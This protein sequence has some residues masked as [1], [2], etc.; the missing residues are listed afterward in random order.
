MTSGTTTQLTLASQKAKERVKRSDFLKAD[1]SVVAYLSVERPV[2]RKIRWASYLL[3]PI[4]PVLVSPLVMRNTPQLVLT[5]RHLYLC[6]MK[7]RGGLSV[8]ARH[9]AGGFKAALGDGPGSKMM[10]TIDDETF[11]VP[12]TEDGIRR[13]QAIVAAGKAAA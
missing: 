13:A 8:V 9:P 3:F 6:T 11:L 12:G 4:G 7:L 1:E 5:E 2:V 10:L